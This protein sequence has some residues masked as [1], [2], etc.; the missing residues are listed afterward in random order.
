MIN[1]NGNGTGVESITKSVTDVLAQLPAVAEVLSGVNLPE[2]M[3]RVPALKEK[4]PA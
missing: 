1:S 4:N 3:K 2:L